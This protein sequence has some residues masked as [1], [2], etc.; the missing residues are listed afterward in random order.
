MQEIL[1]AGHLAAA[2]IFRGL[3]GSPHVLLLNDNSCYKRTFS[4]DQILSLIT[5]KLV[6]FIEDLPCMRHDLTLDW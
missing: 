5:V 4:T 1:G 2:I 3:S 6:T